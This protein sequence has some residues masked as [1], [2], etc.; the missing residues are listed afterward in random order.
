MICNFIP[1]M[2]TCIVFSCSSIYHESFC[3]GS[4]KEVCDICE[5]FDKVEA[6]NN[7]I[8]AR[9]WFKIN[10]EKLRKLIHTCLM[11]GMSMSQSKY[12]FSTLC[13]CELDIYYK[14]LDIKNHLE[15]RIKEIERQ[16]P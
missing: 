11:S 4:Y 8:V 7:N 15:R 10:D 12:L 14:T 1:L 9:D 16:I 6:T 3:H 5:I 13:T 2:L